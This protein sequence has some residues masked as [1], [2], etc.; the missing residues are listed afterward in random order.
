MHFLL[1]NLFIIAFMLAMVAC[2]SNIKTEPASSTAP[3]TTG[4][5]VAPVQDGEP[6]PS[7][8]PSKPERPQVEKPKDQDPKGE[9]SEKPPQGPGPN[10]DKNKPEE[11]GN[12]KPPPDAATIE[13]N[14]VLGGNDNFT[15]LREGLRDAIKPIFR[16][17][18][19]DKKV[20]MQG[21]II[22]LIELLRRRAEE[23]KDG[24]KFR[25][26]Y[27]RRIIDYIQRHKLQI[28]SEQLN[29]ILNAFDG[30]YGLQSGVV[31]QANSGL[32]EPL[33]KAVVNNEVAKSL[34]IANLKQMNLLI[35]SIG[36]LKNETNKD[37]RNKGVD[38]AIKAVVPALR[39][40]MSWAFGSVFGTSLTDEEK[41]W[42]EAIKKALG[43][44]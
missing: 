29:P 21:D 2:R 27:H 18:I 39:S 42:A 1:K 5:K 20:E 9:E 38:A 35:D 33:Y 31:A 13:A 15:Q 22:T 10:D 40:Y 6:A 36:V 11:T 4:T 16:Q 44:S 12:Q 14:T 26:P 24:S 43:D 37:K 23:T 25:E 19:V 32:P 34:A 7:Q 17:A 41:A 28:S 30:A 8:V 3:A